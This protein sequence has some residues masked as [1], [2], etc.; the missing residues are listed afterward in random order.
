MKAKFDEG[1]INSTM[2]VATS[3]C[4][5]SRSDQDT[6]DTRHCSTTFLARWTPLDLKLKI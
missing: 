4:H 2:K 3:K 5:L 6:S 1:A